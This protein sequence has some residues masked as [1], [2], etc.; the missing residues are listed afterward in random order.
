MP[1]ATTGPVVGQFLSRVWLPRYSIKAT[2]EGTFREMQTL[3][4]AIDLFV[5]GK[6]V[7]GVD[8]LMSRFKALE[9]R[10]VD[11]HEHVSKYFELIPPGT[12][13]VSLSTEDEEFVEKAHTVAHKTKRR[14]PW[15]IPPLAK[16]VILFVL[17]CFTTFFVLPPLFL[18]SI[19]RLGS[20]PPSL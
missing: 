3:A 2:G 6:T 5:Q 18:C 9:K 8:V 17:F 13:G 4:M 10:T 1:G 19:H 11:G 20:F 15:L 7:Q 16:L 12:Q 14:A